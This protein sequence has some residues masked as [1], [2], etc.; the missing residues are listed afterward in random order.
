MSANLDESHLNT[1]QKRSAAL[2][3][4]D[5]IELD[6]GETAATVARRNLIY[7]LMGIGERRDYAALLRA[8]ANACFQEARL[9]EIETDAMFPDATL[10]QQSGASDA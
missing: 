4:L 2:C 8:Q 10:D 9:L 6:S 5:E 1:P 3:M 7:G